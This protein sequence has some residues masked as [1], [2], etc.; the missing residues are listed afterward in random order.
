MKTVTTTGNRELHVLVKDIGSDSYV[1]IY[2]TRSIVI[3][4]IFLYGET[5]GSAPDEYVNAMIYYGAT[6][7]DSTI[8]RG[9]IVKKPR[10]NELSN[11][12]DIYMIVADDVTRNYLDIRNLSS[13]Q[14]LKCIIVYEVL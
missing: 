11:I 12:K 3:K 6:V 2:F 13:G 5:A 4:S 9:I 1:Q 7:G 8:P 10:I 14:Q